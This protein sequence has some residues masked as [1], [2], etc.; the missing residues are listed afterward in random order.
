MIICKYKF[1]SSIYSNLIPEFNSGY[2]G[3]AVSD[4]I[5]ENIVTRT[6]ECDTLPTKINFGYTNASL[7]SSNEA[8]SLIEV[9]FIDVSNLNGLNH[10]FCNCQNLKSINVS[11]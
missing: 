3:Y 1:D 7:I 11:P 10:M 4:E 6:I 5:N 9:L 2:T 8:A